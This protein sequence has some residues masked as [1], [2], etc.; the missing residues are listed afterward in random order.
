[1][2]S[3]PS[4]CFVPPSTALCHVAFACFPVLLLLLGDHSG[5]RT[6]VSAAAPGTTIDEGRR[7]LSDPSEKANPPLAIA[8]MAHVKTAQL[9]PTDSPHFLFLAQHSVPCPVKERKK[10]DNPREG[11]ENGTPP[12]H[13]DFKERSVMR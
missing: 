10:T 11:W 5:P 3:P 8:A 4:T 9:G 2:S 7:K 13:R 1:M 12:P 6:V